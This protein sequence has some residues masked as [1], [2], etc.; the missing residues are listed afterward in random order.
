MIL[1]LY[2]KKIDFNTDTYRILWTFEHHC[3]QIEDET[4]MIQLFNDP[5]LYIFYNNKELWKGCFGSMSII[6]H[7]YLLYINNKYNIS[8]LLDCIQNKY[9]R[10]SLERVIGCLLQKDHITESLLGDMCKYCPFGISYED[11]NKYEYQNLP[12]L[13]IWGGRL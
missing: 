3:D 4:R 13:K 7:D 12:L 5:E 8:K 11:I 1:Y 10:M 9:N 2:R 6:N